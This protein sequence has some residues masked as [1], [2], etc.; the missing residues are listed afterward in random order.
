WRAASAAPGWD[1]PPVWVHGDLM[2]GNLLVRSG[3]LAGVIDWGLLGVGDPACDLLVAWTLL[4]PEQ[5]HAFRAGLDVDDASWERGRGWA[6][7]TALNAIPY[8][9][10]AN[11]GLVAN[12][13]YRLGQ[14]LKEVT[15]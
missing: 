5:R 3:R 2:P 15:A 9:L 4:G 10:H 13:R 8:Y 12:A 11:P 1:G 6:L 7:V 14:V